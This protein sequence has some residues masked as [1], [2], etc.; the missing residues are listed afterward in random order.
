MER[1]VSFEDSYT[2]RN[3]KFNHMFLIKLLLRFSFASLQ[4]GEVY[5]FLTKPHR[6]QGI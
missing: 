1:I 5:T 4:I 2:Y 3:M 6:L